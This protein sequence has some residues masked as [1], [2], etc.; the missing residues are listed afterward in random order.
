M[1][2][3][4]N[5]TAGLALFTLCSHRNLRS[6]PKLSMSGRGSKLLAAPPKAAL[7]C[8]GLLVQPL[9]HLPDDV[10]EGGDLPLPGCLAGL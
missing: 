2:V 7:A 8:L 3:V 6:G 9:S 4:Q 1:R 10:G 5:Q